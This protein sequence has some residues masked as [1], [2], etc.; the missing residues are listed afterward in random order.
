MLVS[1]NSNTAAILV[2]QT[3][4]VGVELFSEV[5]A[6]FCGIKPLVVS[7]P[8]VLRVRNFSSRLDCADLKYCEYHGYLNKCLHFS[9][10]L[11]KGGYWE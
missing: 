10:I 1:Q 11:G 7:T 5:H 4:P 6:F 2:S 9:L 3:S 8:S